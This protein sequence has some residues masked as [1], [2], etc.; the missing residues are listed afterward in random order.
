MQFRLLFF[1]AGTAARGASTINGNTAPLLILND[2]IVNSYDDVNLQD[3]QSVEIITDSRVAAYGV[4]GA[5]G[6]ARVTTKGVPD[7]KR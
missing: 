7:P 3:V 1:F 5:N 6:V 2:Q 4:R